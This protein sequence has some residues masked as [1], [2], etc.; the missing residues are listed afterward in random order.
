MKAK[1]SFREKLAESHDLPRVEPIIPTIAKRW[2]VTGTMVIP[3]PRDVDALM[4][5]VPRGQLIT[6]NQIGEA[7]A[8][9]HGTTVACRI[10]TGIFAS[11]AAHAAAE[12]EAAGCKRVTPYWRTLKR[13]GEINVKYPGG[14]AGQKRRLEAEGHA[15]VTRGKRAFVADYE[16]R[17]V[18]D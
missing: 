1:K 16:R 14:L 2:G 13:D 3:A 11:I 7:L 15:V 9:Q 8:R 18:K 5:R 4:R 12:D 6:V 17:L 10:T